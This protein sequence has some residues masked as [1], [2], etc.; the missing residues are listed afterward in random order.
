MVCL[1]KVIDCWVVFWSKSLWRLGTAVLSK[2]APCLTEI[3]CDQAST[4]MRLNQRALNREG[5]GEGFVWFAKWPITLIGRLRFEKSLRL[6]TELSWVFQMFL[7]FLVRKF[8]ELSCMSEKDVEYTRMQAIVHQNVNKYH[9]G[10][11]CSPSAAK[12]SPPK[13]KQKDPICT[14]KSSDRLLQIISRSPSELRKTR[15]WTQSGARTSWF[16]SSL[17]NCFERHLYCWFRYL[18]KALEIFR[19]P[20]IFYRAISFKC[21]QLSL[22]FVL[23]ITRNV[24]SLVSPSRCMWSKFHWFNLRI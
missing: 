2:E 5:R 13:L 9:A 4:T 8:G 11:A 15:F 12:D 23:F 10:L 22:H 7:D 17:N 1:C 21:W 24:N 14:S 16:F 3:K 20:M 6:S 18:G 19:R